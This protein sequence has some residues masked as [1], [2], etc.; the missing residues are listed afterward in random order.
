MP[1]LD[2]DLDVSKKIGSTP[3]SVGFHQGA[4]FTYAFGGR[5]SKVEL[6]EAD[7]QTEVTVTFAPE[8]ENS[9]E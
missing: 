9:I 2:G 8:T 1:C 6:K 3:N 7:G 5:F 4:H